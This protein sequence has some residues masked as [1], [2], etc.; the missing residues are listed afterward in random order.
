MRNIFLASTALLLASAGTAAAQATQTASYEVQAIN[1]ISVAGSPSL[2]IN[3]ATAGSAPTA[4]TAGATYAIT[5]NETNR[6]ITAGLDAA[7]PDGV[8]LSMSLAAPTGA[9]SA[10][11][12][13]LLTTAQDVVTAIS[14]L[15]ESGLSITYGLSATA[16]AGV[17]AAGTRT[18]TFTI[19]AGA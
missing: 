16:A 9:T 5:T 1:Q 7:M 18:V 10:G 3:T 11:A 12:V 2:T 17:V 15:N 6:K 13:T 19:T 4:V 14:T 8:S